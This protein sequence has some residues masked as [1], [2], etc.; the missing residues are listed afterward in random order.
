MQQL[1]LCLKLQI[2]ALTAAWS[3][4]RAMPC[5]LSLT[6]ERMHLQAF[7]GIVTVSVGHCHPRVT[8]AIREQ[9]RLL[10][11]TTTIYLHPEVA[12]YAKEL[13]DRMPG[14][15]KVMSALHMAALRPRGLQ[16]HEALLNSGPIDRRLHSTSGIAIVK[17][18]HAVLFDMFHLPGS[19]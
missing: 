19:D 4:A 10:Q 3:H 16:L 17:S 14:N 12:Q 9:S 18:W 11:H 2:H 5:T 6:A 13:T 15:L 8:A 1:Q 7:A